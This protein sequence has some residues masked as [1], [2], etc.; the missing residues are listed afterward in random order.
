MGGIRDERSP[1]GF[2]CGYIGI[3]ITS[4]TIVD[5]IMGAKFDEVVKKHII[6]CNPI[7]NRILVHYLPLN[8]K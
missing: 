1:N 2:L 5:I 8:Q 7:L 3:G 4:S 6:E